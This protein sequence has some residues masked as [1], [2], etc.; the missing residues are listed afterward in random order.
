L[1]ADELMNDSL[2][3]RM[4]AMFWFRNVA[5]HDYRKL[6]MAILRSILDERLEDFRQFARHLIK[7]A[8]VVPSK[9][10]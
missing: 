3:Q 1:R 7:W 2:A 5:V 9:K 4:Q 8:A 6:S 10:Q